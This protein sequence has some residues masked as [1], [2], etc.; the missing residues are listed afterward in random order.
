MTLLEG[1]IATVLLA[2]VAVACLD[3]TRGAAQLQH[4]SQARLDALVTAEAALD[5]E[6]LDE[7]G[8]V[9]SDAVRMTRAPYRTAPRVG[10]TRAGLVRVDVEART[11]DGSVVRLSRLVPAAGFTTAR[12]APR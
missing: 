2:L 6:A 4:R 8:M 5:A 7:S 11:A 10:P 1:I 3:G 9:R 12:G